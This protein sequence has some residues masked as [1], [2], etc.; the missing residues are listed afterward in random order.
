MKKVHREGMFFSCVQL[1]VHSFRIEAA[2]GSI[3]AAFHAIL[4][5]FPTKPIDSN[6]PSR[7][8]GRQ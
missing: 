6:S 3:A 7:G 4:E 5:S 8:D 1:P 2:L